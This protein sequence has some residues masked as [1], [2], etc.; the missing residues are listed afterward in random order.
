[1]IDYFFGKPRT[2]KTYRAVNILYEDY[3]KNENI[4]PKFTYILTNI[5]GF[6]FKEINQLFQ[7]RG[8]KSI[9]YKLIWADFYKHLGVLYRMALEEK[10]DVELNR[11]AYSHKINDCLIILDEASLYLKKYDD[12][13]SWYLAYH[14]HFK[15]R[16]II[17]AQ[18][19]KQINAEYVQTHLKC[20]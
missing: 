4:S 11:Y 14:G 8:S 15:V 20:E 1:M 5:G 17:I 19:P 12:V 7:D 3:I 18:S 10:D 6:K 2:G 16:I 13:I 9:S